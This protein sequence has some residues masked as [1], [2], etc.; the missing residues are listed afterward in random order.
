MTANLSAA[1][2]ALAGL[3]NI[4]LH[5][6]VIATNEAPPAAYGLLIWIDGACDWELNRRVGRHY[7]LLPLEA[8]PSEDAVNIEAVYAMRASFAGSDVAPAVLKFFDALVAVLTG[9]ERAL[10]SSLPRLSF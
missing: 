1:S 8:D 3:T 5:A 9:G 7:E 2:D 4:E 6:L 10:A